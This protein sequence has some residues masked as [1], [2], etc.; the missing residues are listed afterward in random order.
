MD[1]IHINWTK[2]YRVRTDA[3]YSVEDF[4][5]LTTIL[6]ALKWREKNG[7]IKMITD[8]VGKEYYEKIGLSKIWDGGIDTSLDHAP[9]NINPRIFWAAGKLLALKNQTA[10]VAVIDTDFIVWDSILFDK[11]PPVTSIHFEDLYDDVYPGPSY[12]KMKREYRFDP[13][14]DWSLR[15]C[16]TA[17]CVFKNR[18]IIARYTDEAVRFMQSIR[19]DVDDTLRYMVF[20]EQRLLPMCAQ[21]MDL[22]FSSFS[23]LERLFAHGE[24]YFTH[25]WGMKQQMRDIPALRYDFCKRCVNRILS[26][27]PY[28]ADTLK[29]IECLKQYL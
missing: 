15:A 4:E 28:M 13:D 20:A 8:S 23:T 7:S 18:E 17:F 6:S 14:W 9:D 10:P 19:E 1:A 21:K 24:N 3:P 26:D 11:L 29:N 16:N 12:F 27:F 2:P 22:Y 5:L 25:T